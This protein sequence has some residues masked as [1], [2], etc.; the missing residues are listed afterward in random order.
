[1]QQVLHG[2]ST[3]VVLPTGMGKSLCYQLAAFVLCKQF[4]AMVL[5]VTPLVSLI[6]DQL[7]H[8]PKSLSGLSLN[9][10]LTGPQRTRVRAAIKAG[11][12]DVLFVSPELVETPGFQFF[13]QGPDIPSIPFACI[14][15]VHCVSEWSHNFRPAYLRLC[16][17]LRDGL[18]IR[19]ILGLTA[20]ATQTTEASVCQHLQVDPRHVIRV[21]PVPN[22]LVLNV[23]CPDNRQEQLAYFLKVRWTTSSFSLLPPPLLAFFFYFS[24]PPRNLG[25]TFGVKE[26][27]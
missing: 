9:S 21:D 14:D 3:L 4:R 1:M 2:L 24:F 27:N 12:V 11:E 23:S 20:T 17:L 8:L 16:A 7:A 22:N 5:V 18:G 10:T 25:L 6:Q 19:C 13:M 15:E 26:E